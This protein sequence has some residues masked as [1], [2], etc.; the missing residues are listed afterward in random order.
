MQQCSGT[1]ITIQ[2]LQKI[3]VQS[4]FQLLKIKLRGKKV[5]MDVDTD[6]EALLIMFCFSGFWLNNRGIISYRWLDIDEG[7]HF[8]GNGHYWTIGK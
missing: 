4:A 7:W 1:A 8:L 3:F 6:K 5:S 2:K